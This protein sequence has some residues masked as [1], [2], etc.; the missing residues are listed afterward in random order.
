MF[1]E[2]VSEP[3]PLR[4]TYAIAVGASAGGVQALSR[5][6][7]QLPLGLPAA[8]FI[9]LHTQQGR[10]SL[11]PDILQRQTPLKVEE[12]E[13]GTIPEDGVIYVA[14][15]GKHCKLLADSTICLYSNHKLDHSRPSIIPLFESVAQCFGRKSAVVVLTGHGR[16][17]ASALSSAKKFGATIMVQE[18]SEAFAPSMP[19]AAIDTGTANKVLELSKIGPALV[20]F[21]S[22]SG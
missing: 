12:A 5:L 13:D 20:K 1:Q 4:A 11:L 7:A 6:V 9:V 19:Q 14:P 22:P 16:N 3:V 8:V 15:P 10:R 2:S 17:G 18:P 21:A